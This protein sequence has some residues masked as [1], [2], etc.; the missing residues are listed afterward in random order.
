MQLAAYGVEKGF[1]RHLL[2]E[3]TA[4]RQGTLHRTRQMEPNFADGQYVVQD[5]PLR[6]LAASGAFHWQL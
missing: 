2:P 4:N 3:S 6:P 5:R 1:S